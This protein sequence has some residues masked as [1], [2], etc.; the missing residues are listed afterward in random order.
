MSLMTADGQPPT[1]RICMLIVFSA[2]S[3][4]RSAVRDVQ[5][6]GGVSSYEESTKVDVDRI[7]TVLFYLI[8]LT[9]LVIASVLFASPGEVKFSELPTFTPLPTATP[10]SALATPTGDAET[11]CV[12]TPGG[13]ANGY[14]PDIPFSVE[15]APPDLKGERMV[16]S[17][18]VYAAD[19]LTPLPGAL[20]EVWQADAAGQYDRTAPYILRGKMRADANGRYEFSTIK[21]GPY[22]AGERTGP[23]HIHYQ[24]TYQDHSPFATRLLFKGDPYLSAAMA[25]SPLVIPLTKDKGPAGPILRGVFDLILPIAPPTPTP[26]PSVTDEPL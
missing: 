10:T 14:L 21:P 13:P 19:C 4:H 22:Q 5:I 2:V 15:L 16:I 26:A 11:G 20:V 9:G 24:I 6:Y 18:T 17:G 23:A 1:A 8:V 3:G 7:K 12:P 25:D